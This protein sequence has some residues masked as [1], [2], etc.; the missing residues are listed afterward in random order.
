MA[1][2]SLKCILAAGIIAILAGCG[3]SAQPTG[4]ELVG[5]NITGKL[6]QS[7]KP[8]KLLKDET[9]KI[10]FVGVA[11]PKGSVMGT[12]DMKEDGTFDIAGPAGK[13]LPAGRYKICLTSVVYGTGNDR[14]FEKYDVEATPFF[15]DV[16]ESGTQTYEIDIGTRKA[17]KK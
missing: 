6:M 15:V 3:K 4:P 9:I 7:G 1:L 14:F 8:I 11:D 10:T 2:H 5:S 16:G 13:G 17:V 12:T